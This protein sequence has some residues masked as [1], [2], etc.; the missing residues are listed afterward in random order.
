VQL[1][2]RAQHGQAGRA[3]LLDRVHERRAGC[4][5][6]TGQRLV[7]QEHVRLLR[8][9]PGQEHALSLPAGQLTHR[10]ATQVRDTQPIQG[11]D[12]CSDVHG[13]VAAGAAAEQVPTGEHDVEPGHRQ[14]PPRGAAL[15]DVGHRRPARPVVAVRGVHLHDAVGRL[16]AGE[17]PQQRGLA[18]TVQADEGDGLAGGQGQVDVPQGTGPAEVHAHPARLEPRA[19]GLQSR[20]RRRDSP[21]R[22][23]T[24]R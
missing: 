14:V 9:R 21:L 18:G 22:R 6:Q 19:H 3:Q 10:P 23:C 20:P 16:Q 8:Q 13:G 12:S 7:E 2:Q 15:R 5:V 1:V 17:G 11:R 4:G 24:L